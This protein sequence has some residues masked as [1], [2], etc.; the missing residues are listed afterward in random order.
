MKATFKTS[1]TA[2]VLFAAIGVSSSFAQTVTYNPGDIVIGFQAHTENSP[3]VNQ[4][5]LFNVGA[6]AGYKN[7]SLTLGYDTPIANIGSQLEATYGANWFTRSDVSWGAIGMRTTIQNFGD[8]GPIIDG[9]GKGVIYVSKEAT[10]VGESTAWAAIGRGTASTL[11][12]R[13]GSLLHISSDVSGTFS[14]QQA[15]DGTNGLG[16]FVN[17]SAEN[18]W[19]G[20]VPGPGESSFGSF[21]GGIEGSLGTVGQYAYLDIYRITP[22]GID[23]TWVVTFAIDSLGNVYA[24]PEPSTYAAILAIGA[25]GVAVVRRRNRKAQA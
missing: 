19:S 8:T 1:A 4:N 3:G 16:V 11:S 7:G 9:D 12:S 24:V 25:I 18:S 14:K 21:A 20:R 17:A 2:V 15:A 5:F 10:G 6:S 22:D 23:P 13:V